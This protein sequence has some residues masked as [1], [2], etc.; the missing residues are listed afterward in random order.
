MQ[1]KL[2]SICF[3]IISISKLQNIEIQLFTKPKFSKTRPKPLCFLENILHKIGDFSFGPPLSVDSLFLVFLHVFAQFFVPPPRLL[4]SASI[5]IL[6]DE[7][8]LFSF[9][10]CILATIPPSTQWRSDAATQRHLQF[11]MCRKK[12]YIIIYILLYIIIY[13][14][15]YII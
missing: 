10:A 8:T 7:I 1:N 14:N 12:T 4:Q 6:N 9:I 11:T 2:F 3:R 13:N 5:N 15:I